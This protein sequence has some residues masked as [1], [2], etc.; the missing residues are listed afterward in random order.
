[1]KN[2]NVVKEVSLI[3]NKPYKLFAKYKHSAYT[4]YAP[5]KGESNC[6]DIEREDNTTLV[7][8]SKGKAVLFVRNIDNEFI[9]FDWVKSREK[10]ESNSSS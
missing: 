2:Q 3:C 9:P 10:Y 4:Q 5:Y 8:N 7:R 1:M 6:I